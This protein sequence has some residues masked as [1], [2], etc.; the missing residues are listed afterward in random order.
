M[1]SRPERNTEDSG[2]YTQ[3]R[4]LCGL[5]QHLFLKLSLKNN[6]LEIC[7]SLKDTIGRLS[8]LVYR[9]CVQLKAPIMQHFVVLTFCGCSPLSDLVT[10]HSGSYWRCTTCSMTF[11]YVGGNIS[12]T[13]YWNLLIVGFYF[14]C[15]RTLMF[16][17]KIAMV[18]VVGLW[19]SSAGR[20][21]LMVC[22]AV[23]RW[24]RV[25]KRCLTACC[26]WNMT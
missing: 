15:Q 19:I 22:E 3:T 16:R 24:D 7:F 17:R 8:W 12:D 25:T 10:D 21:R 5:D 13:G 6:F 9:V 18:R 11:L 4:G 23:L 1:Y 20:R 2:F 26:R 14:S